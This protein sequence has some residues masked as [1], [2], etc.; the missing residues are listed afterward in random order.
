MV[1][2]GGEGDVE[3]KEIGEG[4]EDGK[5]T[6]EKPPEEVF[7]GPKPVTLIGVNLTPPSNHIFFGDAPEII[8]PRTSLEVITK[9]ENAPAVESLSFQLTLFSLAVTKVKRSITM[10]IIPLKL[11]RTV[12][13]QN[14]TTTPSE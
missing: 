11:T 7:V 3:A 2:T 5:T 14:A 6:T 4:N 9:E 1:E 8:G 12:I 13:F 10:P